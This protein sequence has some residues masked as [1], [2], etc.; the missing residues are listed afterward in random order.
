MTYLAIGIIG[1]AVGALTVLALDAFRS[2]ERESR[3]TKKAL[4]QLRKQI[5]ERQ[6]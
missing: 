6:L 2:L 1:W 3:G 4:K 5:K